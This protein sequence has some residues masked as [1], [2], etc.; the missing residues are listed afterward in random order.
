MAFAIK[1]DF[2][3]SSVILISLSFQFYFY[4]RVP[5]EL[6]PPEN[7]VTATSKLHFRT[8][9]RTRPRPFSSISSQL[10]DTFYF[11]FPRALSI[12]SSLLLFCFDYFII[13]TL[14]PQNELFR[15][16]LIIQPPGKGIE[17]DEG[18]YLTW[19]PAEIKEWWT[20]LSLSLPFSI[21]LSLHFSCNTLRL[22]ARDMEDAHIELVVNGGMKQIELINHEKLKEL[23]IAHLKDRRGDW[24]ILYEFFSIFECQKIF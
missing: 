2:P 8:E 16:S 11:C 13:L 21:S 17:R 4:T 12:L 14:N 1:V 23:G 24:K 5:Y 10:S 7:V 20:S 6:A 9:V 19:S 18:N 3:S 22:R 15:M